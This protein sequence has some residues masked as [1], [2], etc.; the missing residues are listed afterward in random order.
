M[1]DSDSRYLHLIRQ[2]CPLPAGTHTIGYCRESTLRWSTIVL[3][4][5][6][7][8]QV[9]VQVGNL[10]FDTTLSLFGDNV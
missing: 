9:A 4:E 7:R 5:R 2:D 6:L 8:R 1:P 10:E 3:V